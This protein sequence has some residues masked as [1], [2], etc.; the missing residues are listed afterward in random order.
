M[1]PLR[2]RAWDEINK[3]MI[4]W[5]LDTEL[6]LE[7]FWALNSSKIIMQFSGLVDKNGKDIYEDDILSGKDHWAYGNWKKAV[8]FCDGIFWPLGS[9]DY[10]PKAT[11]C[12][13]IGNIHENPELLNER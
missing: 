10:S 1:R 8:G 9:D 3:R 13:I 4:Y 6:Y 2:F 5:D 7:A 11:D 12:E